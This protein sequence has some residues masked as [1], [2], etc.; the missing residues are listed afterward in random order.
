MSSNDITSRELVEKAFLA[1]EHMRAKLAIAE[2]A[3]REPL[4]VTGLACR[5]PHAPN[6]NAFWRLLDEGIDATSEAP[7]ERWSREWFNPD[8]E[9]P[10]KMYTRRGGFLESVDAFDPAFFHIAPREA[11]SMDPQQRLLL[12]VAWE[13]LENANIPADS[14]IDSPTGVFIGICNSDYSYLMA[15]S[16]QAGLID[17]YSG[18]GNSFSVTAGRLSFVL[19]LRGPSLAIDTACSSSLVALDTACESLR[20]RRCDLA[21]VGG[22]NL[23]LAPEST[24][25]FCKVRALSRAGRCATFDAAADGYARGEGCGVVVLKRLAEAQAAGD[26]ILAVVRGSAVNHDGRSSGLTTPSGAAQDAVIRAALRDAG[27]EPG[28]VSYVE[29]HGT[30]TPLGDPI[31]MRAL[32]KVLKEGR[33]A[34]NPVWVGSVKT[35]IGHLEGAA[36]IAGFIKVVLSLNHGR[37]PAHLHFENPSP[38]I[39]WESIPVRVPTASTDWP[40]PRIAGISSFG[41]GGTNAHLVLEAPEAISPPGPAAERPA[42]LL[43]VSG[44]TAEAAQKVAAEY[45]TVLAGCAPGDFAF[46][47]ATCRSHFEHRIAVVGATAEEL[48][49]RLRNAEPEQ[50]A[51]HTRRAVFLF[52]G[53]GAQY[54]EMGRQLYETQPDFRHTIDHCQGI[55]RLPLVDILRSPDIHQTAYTQ[56]ALFALEY[57]LAELWR[58]W[59]I[60][61]G[62]VLGHSVGEFVAACVAGVFSLED[63][64]RLIAARGRLMQALPPG[65]GMAAVNAP[66]SRLSK[67]IEPFGAEV[68]IAAINGPSETVISGDLGVLERMLGRLEVEGVRF[69]RLQ[70]SHAFHSP[71]MD[72]ALENFRRIAETVEYHAPRLPLISNLSGEPASGPLDAEYWA[73]HMRDPVRFARGMAILDRE[74][75]HEY[76]EIGPRPVLLSLGRRCIASRGQAW[77]PSLRPGISDWVQM[78]DSLG[79]FYRRGFA[80]DWA[81]FERR[82]PHR[83]VTLPNY[84]FQRQR[85]WIKEL[86]STSETQPPSAETSEPATENGFLR[87]LASIPGAER[88][89]FLATRVQSEVARVLRATEPPQRQRGFFEMGMDSLMA[90]EL[91][92][93]FEKMLGREMPATVAFDH[94]NINA[95]V[96]F[97]L[98]SLRL[99][100]QDTPS[101]DARSGA[102]WS[103]SLAILGMACRFPGGAN[104]PQAFWGLLRNGVDA[105]GPVPADRWDSTEYFD[106]DPERAGRSYAQR[107]SFLDVPVLGFDAR[108]FGIAGREAA[109]MDPQQRMLLELCWEA[110]ENAGLAPDQLR[111]ARVGVFVGIN[112][113]DYARQIAASGTELDAYAFTGNTFSVAAGR[114]SHVL[115]FEGPSLAVDTACSSSLVAAHLACQSLRSGECDLALAAGISLMLSPEGNV[116]LSRMRALSPDGRCKSFD[117]SAD[118]YGRGEGGGA[119]VLKRF[120]DARGEGDS[121]IALVRGSAI[122]HDGESGGL[123]VPSGPAQARLIRRALANA[124]VTPDQVAYLEAHGTGTPLGDPIELEAAGEVYGKGR[125][126][127]L[128]VGSVKTNIGHLEAAAGVASLMKV[129]LALRNGEIPPHL[130]FREPN[131][132]IDWSKLPLRVVTETEA[133]PEGRRLAAVSSFGMSGTNAHM[134]LEEYSAPEQPSPELDRPLHLLTVSART[135]PAL[136]QLQALYR[137]F[138]TTF[139]DEQFADVCHTANAGR[140]HFAHRRAL[141]GSGPGDL[142]EIKADS[143]G[144]PRIAFLFTGQGSQYAGMGRELYYSHP[145]FRQSIEQCEAWLAPHMDLPLREVLWGDAAGQIDQTIYSQPAI[146]SIQIALAALWRQW[147]IEPGAVLGHSVGEYAAAV[148]AG[149]LQGPDAAAL[150]AARGKLMQALPSGGAMLALEAGEARVRAALPGFQH[151]VSIAAING[152]E[153]TV[154]SG[155]S[156]AVQL[157]A[158]RVGAVRKELRVS[159]AFH[160]PLIEP[161]LDPFEEAAASLPARAPRLR[162][163]SGLTGDQIGEPPTAEYWRLQTRKPVRFHVASQA[164][165]SAGYDCF[166][167]IGPHPVLLALAASGLRVPSL[168]RGHGEWRQMLESLASLYCQGAAVDWR[169]FDAGYRRRKLSIPTYPFQRKRYTVEGPPGWLYR[170][171]WELAAP[172]GPR[173]SLS[174]SIVYRAGSG[175]AEEMCVEV[176]QRIQEMAAHSI[177][178]P[179]RLWIITRGAQR[180]PGDTCPVA[181]PATTLWGLGRVIAVEHPELWGGLIDLD[182]AGSVDEENQVAAEIALKG[183]DNQIAF[184]HGRRYTARLDRVA[185]SDAEP[186][187]FRREAAYLITGGLGGLGLSVAN[188]MA[189]HG[190]GSLILV[191]RGTSG[192]HASREIAKM[193]ARGATVLTMQADVAEDGQLESALARLGPIP[194]VRG[195]VHAAGV[196]QDALLVNQ[197][198]ER[199][200]AV[201]RPKVQGAWNLHRLSL[202]WPLEFFVMFSS[203]ASMLGSPG[204]ANYAAA[205]AS[206]DALAEF[207]R[208]QGLP[209]V[210]VNWGPWSDVGMAADLTRR[211]S[212]QWRPAGLDPIPLDRGMEILGSVM[213]SAPPTVAVLP[214]DWTVFARQLPPGCATQMLSRLVPE[215]ALAGSPVIE[216]EFL[217]RLRETPAAAQRDELIQLLERGISKVVGE[218]ITGMA[219]QE[220][221]FFEMG[222][223]SLMAVEFQ[224]KLSGQLGLNL[225]AT[226]LFECPTIGALADYLL[227]A[228][229]PASDSEDESALLEQLEHAL[230]SAADGGVQ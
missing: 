7:P 32:G 152:A 117:A 52:T 186:A 166:V 229:A 189:D 141:L 28:A 53:Q 81:K 220:Q 194:E 122:N 23:I 207:R 8:P 43:V 59:G 208:L 86:A 201:M 171:Q 16:G 21:L 205:N 177:N 83:R 12:E 68:S 55:L 24:V 79:G 135:E 92:T 159:H 203:G 5:F 57:A 15:R 192:E 221:R 40:A 165:A 228:L 219:E 72:P 100:E 188:W 109:G 127:A 113:N 153:A 136:E 103:E 138:L 196:L 143:A 64:L 178:T 119:I 101:E 51:P 133:W 200:R 209:G 173:S 134:V 85:Y 26:R 226:L 218:N 230:G 110:L 78:L 34:E 174:P 89:E 22:V 210:A 114:I 158:D 91:K 94:P 75:F 95:I 131:P 106:P 206:L 181:L 63:A 161:M 179:A 155:D 157:V 20:T 144:H 187:R 115:G 191:S 204:Q 50:A 163:I 170:V 66:E 147:G 139:P 180:L 84:P 10:G 39:N 41:F 25:Y 71:L 3:Q 185:E 217:Q 169:A 225:P 58:S 102:M 67:L 60:E 160:S 82:W 37:I 149:A 140:S 172:S 47:A 116:V 199:F 104:D 213:R 62:A 69:T 190:A 31:E 45:A 112:T 215:D 164:L 198:P 145:G 73:R 90:V 61:P 80:V 130:H 111:G 17:A 176:L 142:I 151:A 108:F 96:R 29:A 54:E 222:L 128:R 4:A 74:G 107:A 197:T 120:S 156:N 14:L 49:A 184:R 167:E 118:G 211:S 183:A 88:F 77:L 168:R 2:R 18:T 137:E 56:P 1:V 154:I 36:G 33:R 121:I 124:N 6:A 70:V 19:G 150:I 105:S 38:H 125:A 148:I 99:G 216:S 93:R 11:A 129:A 123:T 146:F 195:V 126:A 42:H 35:N 44:R 48:A 175:T 87:E 27:I 162:W 224:R 223:D 76:L 30:G 98:G 46:T 214:I 13:A 182:P 227:D 132:R 202:A 9:A 212:R 65:G 193:R 97:I